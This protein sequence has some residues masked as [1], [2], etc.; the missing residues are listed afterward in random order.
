MTHGGC[1]NE[2]EG[3]FS[4]RDDKVFEWKHPSGWIAG[5]DVCRR[6]PFFDQQERIK[7]EDVR[8]ERPF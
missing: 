5:D 1:E 6:P 8:S 2:P 7:I 4:V 3:A